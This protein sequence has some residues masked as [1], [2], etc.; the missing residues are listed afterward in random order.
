MAITPGTTA[1]AGLGPAKTGQILAN[2]ENTA[3][4]VAFIGRN[5]ITLDGT[6]T[7][8]TIPFI[9]GT[10]TI[11][12]NGDAAGTTT[13]PAA[14]T[15]DLI[16][17]STLADLNTI[18]VNAANITTTGFELFLSAAGTSGHTLTVQFQVYPVYPVVNGG[19]Q[20]L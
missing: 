20:I 18:Q 14:V 19:I 9:D 2:N 12:A 17:A 5:T 7:T 4:Q 11:F 13:A 1:Y 10:Q 8:V 15:V 16:N 3:R 6:A